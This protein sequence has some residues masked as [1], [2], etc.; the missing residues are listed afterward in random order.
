M[1]YKMPP[2]VQIGESDDGNRVLNL[3]GLKDLKEVGG[4]KG[5][6]LKVRS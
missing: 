4:Q 1:K 6:G 3:V 2:Q 5:L